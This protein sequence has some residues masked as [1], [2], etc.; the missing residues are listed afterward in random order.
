MLMILFDACQKLSRLVT[1]GVTVFIVG[2]VQTDSTQS[3]PSDNPSVQSVAT[4][5]DIELTQATERLKTYFEV[6]DFLD[7]DSLLGDTHE[8]RLKAQDRLF[9]IYAEDFAVRGIDKEKILRVAGNDDGAKKLLER[10]SQFEFRFADYLSLAEVPV[11]ARVGDPVLGFSEFGQEPYF[12]L[13]ITASLLDTPS[14]EKIVLEQ[15]QNPHMRV[16]KT[17]MECVFFLSPTRTQYY[18]T[19]HDGFHSVPYQDFAKRPKH[20]MNDVFTT[21]CSKD[22]QTFES[23]TFG[24]GRD[25][26]TKS[27]ILRFTKTGP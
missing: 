1:L 21:Y 19:Y 4:P 7:V 12:N 9:R 18:H 6:L 23:Q 17:G 5:K 20:F 27:E 10:Y 15:A 2:C 3:I 14:P 11:L 26:I 25:T 22:G 24:G 8:K 16:L 13:D